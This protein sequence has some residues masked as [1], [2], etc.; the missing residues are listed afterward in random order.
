MPLLRFHVSI[1]VGVRL[2]SLE[3][4]DK[5]YLRVEENI[6]VTL[7]H[8]CTHL[9]RACTLTLIT[10]PK[11]ISKW[12]VLKRSL[13]LFQTSSEQYLTR[14]LSSSPRWEPRYRRSHE[15]KGWVSWNQGSMTSPEGSKNSRPTACFNDLTKTLWAVLPFEVQC[16]I[17]TS[18]KQ[19]VSSEFRASLW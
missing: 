11:Q 13:C 19:A 1:P 17:V 7:W 15:E 10:G 12:H 6:S 18:S 5:E 8:F 2:L 4:A 14:A 9:H 16:H 3:F